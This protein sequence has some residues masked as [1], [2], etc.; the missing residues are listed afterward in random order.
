MSQEEQTEIET[1]AEDLSL[2]N[3]I[4]QL[5]SREVR[6][7]VAHLQSVGARV[8]VRFP[9]GRELPIPCDHSSTK[10]IR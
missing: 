10:A 9:N 6:I 3:E 5:R 7:F 4:S 8:F 1:G 2:L